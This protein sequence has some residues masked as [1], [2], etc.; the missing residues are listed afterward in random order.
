MAVAPRAD[1]AAAGGDSAAPRRLRTVPRGRHPAGRAAR[2][3]PSPPLTPRGSRAIKDG[4]RSALASS[5]Q[6]RHSRTDTAP[7]RPTLHHSRFPPPLHFSASRKRGSSGRDARGGRIL[8]RE[9]GKRRQVGGRYLRPPRRGLPPAAPLAPAAGEWRR[10]PPAGPSA[11]SAA[12]PGAGRMAA[13]GSPAWRAARGQRRSIAGEHR[14][15]SSGSER[16]LSPPLRYV[17]GRGRMEG[18]CWGCGVP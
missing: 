5:A 2:L 15:G 12:A 14:T 9:S 8:L 7:L 4:S 1:T 13:R 16:P 10:L 3:P 17:P 18:R 11:A 6:V